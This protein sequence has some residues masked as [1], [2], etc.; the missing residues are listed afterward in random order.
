[1][2]R[3]TVQWLGTLPTLPELLYVTPALGDPTPLSSLHGHCSHK[4]HPHTH[5]HV[6]MLTCPHMHVNTNWPEHTCT[7]AGKR[8]LHKINKY[9]DTNSTSQQSMVWKKK[10]KGKSGVQ[11]NGSVGKSSHHIARGP[12]FQPAETAHLRVH[13]LYP[14]GRWHWRQNL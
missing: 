8:V 13:S 3:E 4:L 14:T 9:S 2:A 12:E 10:A 7:L 11:R 5:P 1:M 6:C